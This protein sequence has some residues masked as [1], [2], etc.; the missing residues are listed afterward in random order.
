[1][2]DQADLT[3][4][5][6]LSAEIDTAYSDN[7]Q[8][9]DTWWMWMTKY[10]YASQWNELHKVYISGD[11]VVRT[12]DLKLSSIETPDNLS[13]RNKD[14]T[15]TDEEVYRSANTPGVVYWVNTIGFIYNM[16]E[17]ASSDSDDKFSMKKYLRGEYALPIAISNDRTST[18]TAGIV[19]YNLDY[20]GTALKKGQ[21]GSQSN[22]FEIG[23]QI[24]VPYGYVI[25]DSGWAHYTAKASTGTVSNNAGLPNKDE[26]FLRNELSEGFN[27]ELPFVISEDEG[28]PY[29]IPAPTGVYSIISGDHEVIDTST[30]HT[31]ITNRNQF[32]YGSRRIVLETSNNQDSSKAYT[33]VSNRYNPI[34]FN[35]SSISH[36]AYRVYRNASM[37]V[38]VM[39]HAGAI[40]GGVNNVQPVEA[41][42]FASSE[43]LDFLD[44]LGA[45]SLIQAIDRGSSLLIMI[46]FR[47]LPMIG[48]ILMTILVGLAFVSDNR[49]VQMLADKF[50]DPIKL[51]TFGNKDIHNWHWNRVLI[52]CIC[53]YVAFALFLNGNIIRLVM[54]IGKWYGIVSNFFLNR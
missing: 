41:E 4:G 29:F 26:I 35:N 48:I 24:E 3:Y 50:V 31:Y 1:M 21:A 46:A 40:V 51:L 23:G 43:V 22:T 13:W 15:K 47:L 54:W 5:G 8:Y 7:S 16:P 9:M 20:Y 37:D 42:D 38:F 36:K 17:I 2:L 6:S 45:N 11:F 53:L 49:L 28:V 19:N 44:G 14:G 52:P 25:T 27:A 12:F 39:E 18:S 10:S 34:Q 33:I 32:Y 30:I